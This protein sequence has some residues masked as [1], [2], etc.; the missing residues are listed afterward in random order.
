[1]TWYKCGGSEYPDQ[2]DISM[3]ENWKLSDLKTGSTTIPQYMFY[4]NTD[5]VALDAP[6]IR[7]LRSYCFYGCENVRSID[8]PDLENI[9]NRSFGCRRGSTTRSRVEINLPKLTYIDTYGFY[10]YGAQDNTA[11]VEFQKLHTVNNYAFASSS[12]TYRL[13]LKKLTFSALGGVN[14][15]DYALQRAV[16][17]TIDITSPDMASSF[18]NHVFASGSV[19]NLILRSSV[20]CTMYSGGD[21]GVAPT[22][23]YVPDNLVATY[24]ANSDWAQYTNNIKPLSDI[25]PE[26]EEEE[27]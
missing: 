3:S 5:L 24:K 12:N 21:L 23:I 17:E 9:F 14:F 25:E 8:M 26:E 15:G 13:I 11:E 22:N 16:I 27:P 2:I 1:M 20:M 7:F 19:T 4:G 18:G 6:G 10:E